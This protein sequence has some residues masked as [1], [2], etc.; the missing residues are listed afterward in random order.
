MGWNSWD[1]YMTTVTE[2]D[3]LANATYLH[4][5]FLGLGWNTVVVDASWFDS[6]AKS[7]GY[8]NPDKGAR[9]CLDQYGRQIPSPTRFPSS[10]NGKGFKPL[11]D[12]VHALGLK[13][14]LHVMRGIP[15]QAVR[16]KLPIKGTTYTAADVAD[17]NPAHLCH[18]N[19]DN[20]A[21]NHAHPGSQAWYDSQVDLFASWGVDFLKVDDM[22]ALFYPDEIASYAS[23]IRTAELKYGRP[24]TLSLSPGTQVSVTNLDFLRSHAQMWR[25][26]DDLWDRWSD[27]HAQFARLARWAPL[28]RHGHWADADMLPLGHLQVNDGKGG[29]QSNLTLDEQKTL[30]TLW[31]MAHSPLMVG[32]DLPSSDPKTLHLLS[33]PWIGQV[34]REASVGREIVR[35]PYSRE[36]C[37]DNWSGR[38][39]PEGE[40]I[41]WVSNGPVTGKGTVS[42]YAAL[43]WTGPTAVEQSVDL[44][45]LVGFDD[46]HQHCALTDLWAPQSVQKVEENQA[47]GRS[48]EGTGIPGVRLEGR[49]LFVRIPAHGVVWLR[50]DPRN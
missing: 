18:W 50:F 8:N 2:K 26:S 28:Q 33:N 22:Q 12:K 49:K 41:V 13:F 1:S 3:V 7:A 30:L 16:G 20:Y 46:V 38:H 24:I 5:H 19:N 32:G 6:N 40:F 34:E 44:A 43:F 31:S 42:H 10:A 45:S 21:L 9:F 23:A 39:V 35:E 4:D 25:I 36:D 11:A 37:F 27:V 14:G 29:R 48:A 15:R 47:E 17:T